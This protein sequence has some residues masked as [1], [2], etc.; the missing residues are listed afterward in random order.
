MNRERWEAASVTQRLGDLGAERQAE[1]S[2]DW[3]PELLEDTDP[4]LPEV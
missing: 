4:T 3:I 2:Q 1:Q